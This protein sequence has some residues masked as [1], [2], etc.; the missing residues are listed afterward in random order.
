[1]STD[2][3]RKNISCVFHGLLEKRNSTMNNLITTLIFYP[4]S[5]RIASCVGTA[6]M[7]TWCLHLKPPCCVAL[8]Q[9]L[10]W[11]LCPDW[12]E[13]L[14]THSESIININFSSGIWSTASGW[15]FLW[16]RLSTD[17]AT[18]AGYLSDLMTLF[19]FCDWVY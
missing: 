9:V 1:M 6:G 8:G 7:V 15:Y 5:S 4:P 13:E 18:M 2:D 10:I 17:Q 19:T 14:H 12:F 11:V 3:S 16:S